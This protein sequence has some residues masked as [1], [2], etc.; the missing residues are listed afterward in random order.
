MAHRALSQCGQPRLQSRRLALQNWG[1]ST[2]SLTVNA[3]TAQHSGAHW[4]QLRYGMGWPINNGYCLCRQKITVYESS[5]AV[6]TAWSLCPSWALGRPGLTVPLFLSIRSGQDLSG[7][8]WSGRH[9][10]Q[11]VKFEHFAQ[12]S[13]T[14][15]T[16][17]PSTMSMSLSSSFCVGEMASQMT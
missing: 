17:G 11:H 6:A 13:G 2:D 3:V 4:L 16:T 8:H 15:G 1:A 5:Q 9:D 7:R 12:Y 14:G 10:H